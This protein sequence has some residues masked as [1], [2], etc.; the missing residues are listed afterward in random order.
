LSHKYNDDD[1]KTGEG[2]GKKTEREGEL[3][4]IEVAA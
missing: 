4:K 3:K 2:Y 1:D